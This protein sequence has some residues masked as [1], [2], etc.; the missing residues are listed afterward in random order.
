MRRLLVA[1]T[2]LLLG[3]GCTA[4]PAPVAPT[5]LTVLPVS[6]R[7]AAPELRGEKLD[8]SGT[9]DLGADRGDVV[10]LN[11][12]AQWCGPCVAETEDLVRVH[13]STKDSGVTFVGVNVRDVRA[14][15][16]DFVTEHQV[17]YPNVFDPSSK[18]ALRFEVPPTTI[19]ATIILD[20][21]H[22]VA[23]IA[24]RAV[25]ADELRAVLTQ[26]AQEPG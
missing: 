21:Q 2:V 12:W 16:A 11:F 15:A 4:D 26:L 6:E 1:L 18:V 9:Y 13:Q 20:R 19:P 8:G 5:G 10:V 14:L 24:R 25:V 17:T 7:K 3:A 22:R 23:V